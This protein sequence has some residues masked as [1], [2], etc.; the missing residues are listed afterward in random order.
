MQG[1]TPAHRIASTSGDESDLAFWQATSTAVVKAL[2]E[3]LSLPSMP[4]ERRFVKGVFSSQ[5][6]Y[7]L[8]RTSVCIFWRICK[9]TIP[10]SCGVEKFGIYSTRKGNAMPKDARTYTQEFKLEA[11]RLVE[12]SG[13]SMRKAGS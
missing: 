3:A 7:W 8:L 6:V 4:A 1:A 11:V 9:M 10:L 5:Q 2:P 13:K 12:T